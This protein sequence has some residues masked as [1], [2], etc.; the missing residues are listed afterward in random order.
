LAI[1]QSVAP[2]LDV[3]VIPFGIPNATEIEHSI[4]MFARSPNGSLILTASALSVTHGDLIIALTA[5]LVPTA[6]SRQ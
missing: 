1:I 3:D 6:A 2:S 4:A 5:R